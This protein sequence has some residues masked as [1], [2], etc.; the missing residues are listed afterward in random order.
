MIEAKAALGA[1]AF[2][3]SAFNFDMHASLF[4][5]L[6]SAG[7]LFHEVKPKSER[8]DLLAAQPATAHAAAR[9]GK[10]VFTLGMEGI[11]SRLIRYLGKDIE[12]DDV[13]E[14]VE[15][16]ARVKASELKV[17]LIATGLE[18]DADYQEFDALLRKMGPL[19]RSG[20]KGGMRLVFSLA[21]LIVQPH[22]PLQFLPRGIIAGRFEE[23]HGR[24]EALCL[25]AGAEC[26]A[27]A[28]PHEIDVIQ[29]LEIGDRRL[30]RALV[31]V[32]LAGRFLYHRNIPMG[33]GEALHEALAGRGIDSAVMLEGRDPFMANPWDDIAT[34]V[35]QA[36]LHDRFVL[37]S[38]GEAG[39]YCLPVQGKP[40]ECKHCE[41]CRD[42]GSREAIQKRNPAPPPAIDRWETLQR[43]KKN[44]ISLGITLE[45]DETLRFA[46]P[47]FFSRAAARCLMLEERGLVPAYLRP[48]PAEKRPAL[49]GRIETKLYFRRDTSRD[50]LDL[51]KEPALWKKAS[52]HVREMRIEEIR[53]LEEDQK[54]ERSDSPP[55]ERYAIRL[56]SDLDPDQLRS[57]LTRPRKGAALPLKM[58][59]EGDITRFVPEGKKA[60]QCPVRHA[61][62]RRDE[63]GWF[64]LDLEVKGTFDVSALIKRAL[65]D[66]P[67][68]ARVRRL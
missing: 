47:G 58:F 14:V 56:P 62:T 35:D 33:T 5:L 22:T 7:R 31:E 16:L 45:V 17:F 41:A 32:S 63:D 29:L 12:V 64:R 60:R 27:S 19:A 11:S 18:G 36:F 49:S 51:V 57:A 61:V 48:G 24:I 25:E 40:H 55:V 38:S 2:H 52:R 37:S 54:P 34:G 53:I 20:Q 66:A 3:P 4:P 1:E 9:L 23:V 59:K 44:P 6:E 15:L 67:L 46:D 39:G 43:E 65:P 50:L 26:R 68:R 42:S 21:P 13:L 10:R 30:T 8:F 28:L